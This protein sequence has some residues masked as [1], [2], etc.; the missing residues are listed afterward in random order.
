MPMNS[1]LSIDPI[2]PQSIFA[3]VHWDLGY[4]KRGGSSAAGYIIKWAERLWGR[5]RNANCYLQT[6]RIK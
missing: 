2:E 3:M 5:S 1:A 6:A 4:C